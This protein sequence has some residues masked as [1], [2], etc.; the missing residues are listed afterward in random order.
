M[1]PGVSRPRIS[2]TSSSRGLKS[3]ESAGRLG[4]Q[5]LH[6][7]NLAVNGFSGT[8]PDDVGVSNRSTDVSVVDWRWE[9]DGDYTSDGAVIWQGQVLFPSPRGGILKDIRGSFDSAVEAAKIKKKERVT[10]KTLRHTY[11][12]T[13]LQT[14]DQGAPVSM[15]TVMKELGH[16]SLKMIEERYGH[17]QKRRTRNKVVE[18]REATVTPIQAGRKT[19]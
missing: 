14:T 13:R 16:Q 3:P 12:A 11:T 17:L 9:A 7:F 19:S 2:K 15:F 10:P 5:P 18:Y 1:R 6:L 4:S 8:A